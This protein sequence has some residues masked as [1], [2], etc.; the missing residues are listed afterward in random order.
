MLIRDLKPGDLITGLNK[1]PDLVLQVKPDDTETMH[2]LRLVILDIQHQVTF[3]GILYTLWSRLPPGWVV[4]RA[5]RCIVG[6][7]LLRTSTTK[8]PK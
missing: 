4:Y 6:P 3:T 8:L 7:G 5:G 2:G 1:H